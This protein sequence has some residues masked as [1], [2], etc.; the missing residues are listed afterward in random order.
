M[1]LTLNKI[2]MYIRMHH[3]GLNW[4]GIKRN[5]SSWCWVWAINNVGYLL[6]KDYWTQWT[7]LNKSYI[8]IHRRRSFNLNAFTICLSNIAIW[9]TYCHVWLWTLWFCIELY[10]Y[11]FIWTPIRINSTIFYSW[12]KREARILSFHTE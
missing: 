8:V 6:L 12:P 9:V 7:S 10:N 5:C 1:R 11:S 2:K 3:R 4:L